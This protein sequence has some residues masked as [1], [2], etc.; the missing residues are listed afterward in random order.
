MIDYFAN[1]SRFSIAKAQAELGYA[2]V[3]DL[4]A[5]MAMTEKWARWAN[6]LPEV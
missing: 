2:P 5:G 1:R 3:Y 4:A 6:L